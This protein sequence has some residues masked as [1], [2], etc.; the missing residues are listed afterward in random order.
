[1]RSVGRVCC[2][3]ESKGISSARE[4]AKEIPRQPVLARLVAAAEM[5]AEQHFDPSVGS[6]LRIAKRARLDFV[7]G[8]SGLDQCVANG[9]GAAVTQSLVTRIRSVDSELEG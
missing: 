2:H 9:V 1:M 3:T 6:E 5:S 7:R 4:R 8:H